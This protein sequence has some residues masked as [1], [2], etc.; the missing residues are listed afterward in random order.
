MALDADP[1][2]A[3]L[4]TEFLE[5][6]A[7]AGLSEVSALPDDGVPAV[8]QARL[9]YEAQRFPIWTK[10]AACVAGLRGRSALMAREQRS[11]STGAPSFLALF[12]TPPDRLA[13][14]SVHLGASASSTLS[15]LVA[16]TPDAL[17]EVRAADL[18]QL[19][20]AFLPRS[21]A[22]QACRSLRRGGV[23]AR[24]G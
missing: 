13:V 21:L 8:V 2:A 14:R 20:D 24:W 3:N 16:A 1:T 6:L 5:A 19:I 7:D 9:A 15:H 22:E 4:L 10:L 18:D 17:G 23:I 12:V 11:L